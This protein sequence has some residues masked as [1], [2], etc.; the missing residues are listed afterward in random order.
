MAA[1]I[2]EKTS[3]GVLSIETIEHFGERWA[4]SEVGGLRGGRQRDAQEDDAEVGVLTDRR[5]SRIDSGADADSDPYPLPRWERRSSQRAARMGSPRLPC[6]G[7]PRNGARCPVSARPAPRGTRRYRRS[8]RRIFKRW[9][10]CDAPL[11]RADRKHQRRRAIASAM[12]R[13]LTFCNPLQAGMLLTSSTGR[14]AVGVHKHV[15]A[16]DSGADRFRPLRSRDAPSWNL[17]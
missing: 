8:P 11:D 9:R 1:A 12:L 14:R 4:Q 16:G 15:N 3:R 7:R 17:A 10:S 5:E 2:A 6:R 13:L